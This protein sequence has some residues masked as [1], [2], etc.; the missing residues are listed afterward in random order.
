MNIG[1]ILEV[2]ILKQDN[3]G[4]GIAKHNNFVIFVDKAIKDELVK[5]KISSIK[6]N[7]ANAYI[8]EIIERSNAR[9]EYPCTYYSKCGGCNIG[10]IN[11][12]NQLD[13]KLN[14]LKETLNI[15]DIEII[16]TNEF[17][18]R[19][20]IVLRVKN[21]RVGLYEPLSNN[22]VNIDNCLISNDEINN[23][24]TRLNNFKYLKDI[25]E[26][27]IRS[28]DNT[29]ISFIGNI[30][31]DLLIDTFND[32]SIYL[33]NELIH[34]NSYIDINVLDLTFKVSNNSFFQVNIEGMI[35]LYETIFKSLN[36]N[37]DDRLLDL[38]SGVGT[39]SLYLS[40][41]VKNVIGIEVVK[42][43]V[44]ISNINKEINNI[45]NVEFICEKVENVI[46]NISNIDVVIVDPPRSGLNIKVIDKLNEL[47][48]KTIIYVSCNPD[49]LKRDINLLNYSIDKSYIIDIFPNTY[50]IESV[51]VL[52][53]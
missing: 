19:N 26:V 47:K 13:Y 23:I 37:K 31:K 14:R 24:I 44:D 11:H 32:C 51:T 33:N 52:S 36:L 25:E 17:N 3:F 53:G 48:P 42:E 46:D 39:V 4:K 35:K 8:L 28:L 22:I 18:Y 40:K 38:Y 29:M 49:T 50:H 16:P 1:D 2:K 21:N 43:A 5:I 20:K 45:D 30:S 27:T 34:G 9:R 6:K 10:H 12:P 7:Y 41:Y 15:N